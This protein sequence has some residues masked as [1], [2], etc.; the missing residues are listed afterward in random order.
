VRSRTRKL[1]KAQPLVREGGARPKRSE[2]LDREG[3]SVLTPHFDLRSTDPP[4]KGGCL[5]LRG[6]RDDLGER[7]PRITERRLVYA[8]EIAL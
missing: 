3:E 6:D 7:G 4:I 1:R 8:D 2:G 5:L